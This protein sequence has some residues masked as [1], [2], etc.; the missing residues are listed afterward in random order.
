[1]YWILTQENTSVSHDIEIRYFT[2]QDSV[3]DTGNSTEQKC[4]ILKIK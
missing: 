2:K 4:I 3:Q 1:M